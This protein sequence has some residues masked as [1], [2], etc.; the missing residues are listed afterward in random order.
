VRTGDSCESAPEPQPIEDVHL[1]SRESRFDT[2]WPARGSANLFRLVADRNVYRARRAQRTPIGCLRRERTR[3][4]VTPDLRRRS[5]PLRDQDG[6]EHTHADGD[7]KQP[8]HSTATTSKQ[9]HG[10]EK[11]TSKTTRLNEATWNIMEPLHKTE[12]PEDRHGANDDQ[13]TPDEGKGGDTRVD[14]PPALRPRSFVR[15]R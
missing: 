8:E 2:G 7:E 15:L 1:V 4:G 5:P 14:F 12:G 11:E 13:D 9:I 6:P 10:Q 3:S